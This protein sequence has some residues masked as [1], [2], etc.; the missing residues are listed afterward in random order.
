MLASS[1]NQA[2]VYGTCVLIVASYVGVHAACEGIASIGS[3]VIAVVATNWVASASGT[4]GASVLRA[5]VVIIAV[6]RSEDTVAAGTRI[7]CA[8]GFV[9]AGLWLIVALARTAITSIYCARV[10]IIAG[11]SGI[12]TSGIGAYALNSLA[13]LGGALGRCMKASRVGV[14]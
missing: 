7:C 12:N 3:T 10:S 6:D 13:V 5:S 4:V 9:V 1:F 2:R 11:N 8:Q 14:A